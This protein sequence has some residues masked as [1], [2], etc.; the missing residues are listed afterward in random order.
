MSQTADVNIQSDVGMYTYSYS[1][2]SSVLGYWVYIFSIVLFIGCI[3]Y[4]GLSVYLVCM[5][6]V[7]HPR[8][9]HSQ[10]L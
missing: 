7:C 10:G 4:H 3:F 2:L 9:H 6:W 1:A 5:V 8:V